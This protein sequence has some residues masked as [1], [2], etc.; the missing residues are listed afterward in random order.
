MNF[1]FLKHK[2]DPHLE[3]SDKLVIKKLSINDEVYLSLSLNEAAP[4]SSCYPLIKFK[5]WN[6]TC[7]ASAACHSSGL[8]VRNNSQ[9]HIGLVSRLTTCA[10]EELLPLGPH[11]EAELL[12]PY[13]EHLVAGPETDLEISISNPHYEDVDLDLINYKA[14]PHKEYIDQLS[15]KGVEIGPGN[16][17]RVTAEGA[18]YLEKHSLEDWHKS[19]KSSLENSGEEFS[20]YI[21]GPAHEIPVPDNS[22]NYI[23]SS[24]VFEHLYNPLG[25]LDAW[26]D[27]LAPGGKV[28]GVVPCIY[29]AKDYYAQPSTAE[30]FEREYLTESFEI[31][32]EAYSYY[33]EIRNWKLTGQQLKDEDRSIHVHFYN[34]SNFSALM[35]LAIQRFAYR[36]FDIKYNRNHKD[37]FFELLK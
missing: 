12:Y 37:F 1:I 11:S 10:T 36:A 22:L 20:E 35:E 8:T 26:Y 24:H 29:G 14:I 7:E 23:F 4:Q 17:P 21:V 16:N 30:A 27:K 34:F 28:C 33:A 2:N 25:H 3:L 19:N 31:P 15:G 5:D 9:H 13:S 6:R 32:V 18:L